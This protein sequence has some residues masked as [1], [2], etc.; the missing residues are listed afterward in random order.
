MNNPVAVGY[1][2]SSH[3]RSAVDVALNEARMR[4]SRLVILHSA[5]TPMA[6]M[7]P[8]VLAPWGDEGAARR[9]L[10]DMLTTVADE[11]SAVAPDVPV[12]TELLLGDTV[13]RQ[14]V[15]KSR[16]CRLMVVG[17]RGRGGFKGLLLGSTSSQLAAHAHCPVLVA[18]TD[19]PSP[20]GPVVVGV[21]GHSSTPAVRFAVEEA[22]LRGVPLFAVHVQRRRLAGADGSTVT[23]QA[24]EAVLAEA[25]PAPLEEHPELRVT[26]QVLFGRVREVMLDQSQEAGLLVVGA[27]GRGGLG[28]MRLGSTSQALLYHAPCSVAVVAERA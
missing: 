10:Q 14:L 9:G 13:G 22:S 6:G 18:R 16:H 4:G 20:D 1:D 21:D 5:V 25:I 27:R 11:V 15:E 12:E 8:E 3:S 26:R 28:R 2:G 17:S 19:V 7:P 24:R 23:R